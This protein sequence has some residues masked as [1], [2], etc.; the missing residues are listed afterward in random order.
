MSTHVHLRLAPDRRVLSLLLAVALLWLSDRLGWPAWEGLRQGRTPVCLAG[1]L[2]T[3]VNSRQ[4]LVPGTS[5]HRFCWGPGFGKPGGGECGALGL[6]RTVARI[7]E[8]PDYGQN[9]RDRRSAGGRNWLPCSC[10]TD[11]EALRRRS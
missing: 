3:I 7:A 5:P 6:G 1:G 8:Q 10:H 9:D 4:E 2:F 11:F